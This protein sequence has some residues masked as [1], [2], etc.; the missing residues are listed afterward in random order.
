[1]TRIAQGP[2]ALAIIAALEASSL[3]V[4]DGVAPR[5]GH[6]PQ[7][8]APCVVVHMVPGGDIDGTLGDP[9]GWADA[10]FQ[11]TAVGRVAAEARRSA[12]LADAALEAN[13]VTVPGRVIR[14]L[15]PVEPWGRV[16]IDHDVTPPLFYATRTYGLFTF[17]T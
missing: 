14:R 5:T 2:H 15:R 3:T 8:V 10:R 17:P 11:L 9:E 13:G 4:G 6:P 7:I 1:M 12:D 16:Q